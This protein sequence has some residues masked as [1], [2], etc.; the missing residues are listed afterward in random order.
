MRWGSRNVIRKGRAMEGSSCGG[1][2][3]Q[4]EEP[5]NMGHA[6]WDALVGVHTG[7]SRCQNDLKCGE[8]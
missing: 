4:R 3:K 5:G 1:E 7:S 8:G 2:A 6:M